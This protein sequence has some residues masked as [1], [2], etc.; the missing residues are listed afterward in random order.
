ME[1]YAFLTKALFKTE[2]IKKEITSESK[3]FAIIRSLIKSLRIVKLK[4]G[5]YATINP[6]TGDIFANKFEIATAL[7]KDSF[8]GYHSAL[9]FYGLGTQMFSEIQVLTPT[10]YLS[11]EIDGLDYRFFKTTY[12]KGVNEV[13]QNDTIRVTELERTVVDCIDRIDIAGGIEEVFT[14]L[15]AINYCDEAKILMHLDNYGKK[16]I[17]KK[18][19]YLFSLL[20]PSYL[21]DKFYEECKNNISQRDDDIR[22]NKRISGKYISEWKLIVPET[23]LN[24]E[25]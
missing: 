10:Q 22:E 1:N 9:E 3:M 21:S 17:Y 12:F 15:S 18:A 2:D 14:A 16:Y 7:Q 23:I 6:I 25:N 19:G 8:V 4:G 24:T 13:E 11:Q 5:L 20:K